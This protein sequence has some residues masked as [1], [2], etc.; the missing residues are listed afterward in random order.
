MRKLN[1]SL[2]CLIACLVLGIATRFV[3]LTRGES[4][5]TL[6]E[7][8]GHS[9]TFYHFHPDESTLVNSALGPLDPFDPPLTAYGMLSLYVLRGM[10]ELSPIVSGSEALPPLDAK[11]QAFLQARG[12]S[13][14]F[15]CLT[16]WMVWVLGC[17]YFGRWAAVLATGF[18][19][20]APLAIQQAH[21]YTVDGLFTL[22]S[23]LAL[24]A[25]LRSL[26]HSDIRW[27]VG[28]GLL[29]GVTTAVRL[30]GA[31]LGLVLAAGLCLQ[32]DG[33]AFTTSFRRLAGAAA[34]LLHRNLWLAG[35]TAITTLLVLQP[36]LLTNPSLL[37][38]A[39]THRDFA[40]SAMVARGQILQTWTLVDVPT[41]PYLH[42][43]TSILPTGAGW[44]FALLALLGLTYAVWKPNR[45]K[46]LMLLWCALYFLLVGSLHTKHL[47]YLLPILPFLAV[48]AADLC[49][50]LTKV[51]R[52]WIRTLAATG[53]ALVF[54][55]S[56]VYGL[57][58]T[59]IYS[60]E[61]ARITAGRWITENIPAGSS[62][63]LE[64]GGF[65]LFSV[66]SGRHYN[67]IQLRLNSLFESGAY[68]LCSDRLGPLAG[69]RNLDYI[70]IA[71]VNR[72][73]QFT[74]VPELFPMAAEFYD[75]L[76]DGRLGFELAQ[77]FKTY[78]E[79]WGIEFKDDGAEPSFL[80]YDHP[81]VLIFRK[82]NQQAVDQRIEEWRRSVHG[83]PHCLDRDLRLTA[84]LIQSG[85]YARARRL[86]E[87]IQHRN[88]VSR[89]PH[90]VES[91]IHRRVGDS[92]KEAEA[93]RRYLI[94]GDN[95]LTA[96]LEHAPNRHL[97]PVATA[98]A[99]A[100][101][102]L[103]E[104][105]V[106]VLAAAAA[107]RQA[108]SDSES[109]D[110]ARAYI[111]FATGLPRPDQRPYTAKVLRLAMAI[112]PLPTGYNLLGQISATD[113]DLRGAL[114]YWET[115]LRLHSRQADVLEH[116]ATAAAGLGDYSKALSYLQGSQQL[117]PD[118]NSELPALI[119][120]VKDQLRRHE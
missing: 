61:D 2:I 47:R 108:L 37:S 41:L 105:A 10:V 53:T 115:S 39:N 49:V 103:T 55:Y 45:P 109:L 23:L 11:R 70:V 29:I 43:W 58:F 84:D 50:S 34:G 102:G 4:D 65:G 16:L 17:R 20:V 42:Y 86:V 48:F 85:K 64:R 38:V 19:A 6:P 98:G 46:L 3:G 30:N 60:V 32:A 8:A 1:G 111:H 101:L 114:D 59:R 110:L 88:P 90:L 119:G 78:P 116:A 27:V 66:V 68:T 83:N 80:G 14:L 25:I 13:V 28:S 94:V 74:A 67:R 89:L 100:K 106:R 62:I 87:Q 75:R 33:S 12:L 113:G 57:A 81:R 36:F 118:R 26:E 69:V 22:L 73:V 112:R 76:L 35:G 117:D 54:A 104:L 24:W 5:F 97:V 79:F 93:R 51:G 21:F 56:A 15:S 63:G 71:D 82:P 91:E 120:R 92:A 40:F 18:V 96:H 77:S 7:L 95:T 72:S 52:P 9:S 107:Q 31:L 44:P 99:I